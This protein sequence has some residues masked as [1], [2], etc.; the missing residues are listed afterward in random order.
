MPDHAT[1]VKPRRKQ[2]VLDYSFMEIT[3]VGQLPRHQPEVEGKA[4]MLIPLPPAPLEGEEGKDE[5]AA[6]P[7]LSPPTVR[8]E[9]LRLSNNSL[10]SIAGLSG[11]MNTLLVNPCETIMWMDLSCNGLESVADEVLQFPNL[12]TLHAHGNQIASFKEIRKLA[13]LPQ[14]RSLAMHGN[15][16]EEKKH[17]RM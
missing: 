12:M 13:Q 10:T 17:Y 6:P 8:A 11:I 16:V 5:D 14:L 15:P 1:P 4:R 9:A 7:P 2:V 3:D